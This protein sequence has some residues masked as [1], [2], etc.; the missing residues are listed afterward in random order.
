MNSFRRIFVV[1]AALFLALPAR[2]Q[3]G[4]EPARHV[5]G[6][7]RVWGSAQMQEVMRLWEAGFR[8]LQ[9]D[10]RFR[11]N[12]NGTIS[13]MG[14]LY[15]G[16]ADI[17][18]M[19]REIWPEEEM[20]YK[21][22]TG[23]APTG[24][25]VAMGSFDVPTKADALMIFVN[26]DNPLS[27]IRFDQLRHLFGCGENGSPKWSEAGV[28]GRMGN[29]PAHL[30]GYLPENA[31]S[32]FF[33]ARVLRGTEWNCAYRGFGNLQL[34]GK[35]RIDAG[36]QIIDALSVDPL[37]IAIANIRYATAAVKALALS[38][39]PGSAYVAADRS[40]YLA[41]RYP[42]TRTVSVFINCGPANEGCRPAALEFLRYVLS[43]QGQQDVS[44]EG[45]YQP[46]PAT[47]LQ[48]QWRKL[49]SMR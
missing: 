41:G 46:L 33:R 42:L 18:L 11:N 4:Y 44:R 16:A 10:V 23:S 36:R 40:E 14:G 38:E 37:G 28:S 6:T 19:G 15:G 25:D 5:S 17:A 7:L 1:A 8:R 20:A 31:A 49:E 39:E 34:A 29:E 13:S 27:S 45:A 3:R 9:P 2:A 22:V 30:Y 43:H 24:V 48:A 21:Q 32:R 35:P 12:L 26:R 47:L